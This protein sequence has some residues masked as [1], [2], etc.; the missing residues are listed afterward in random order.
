LLKKVEAW[1]AAIGHTDWVQWH[2]CPAVHAARWLLP[3][4]H[5]TERAF[6]YSGSNR[7]RLGDHLGDVRL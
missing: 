3:R 6:G 2:L 5:E 7:F 1:P 4:I